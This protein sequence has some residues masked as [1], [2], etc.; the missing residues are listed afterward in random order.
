MAFQN[1]A[2][3]DILKPIKNRSQKTSLK[4]I[5][6]AAGAAAVWRHD[7]GNWNASVWPNPGA[8]GPKQIVIKT[9]GSVINTLINSKKTS[10][11]SYKL[12]DNIVFKIGGIQ[13]VKFEQTGR[14]TDTS[15][16][17]IPEST[18]TKMQETGSAWVFKRAIQDNARWN[19]WEDIREDHETYSVLRDIWMKI[20]KVQGPD[21]DWI[22]NFYKQNKALLAKIGRPGFTEF[23]RGSDYTFPGM[24]PPGDT[25]MDWIESKVKKSGGWGLDYAKKDSWN[26]ADIWLVQNEDKWRKLIDDQMKTIVVTP[27]STVSNLHQL[28]A[29]FRALFKSRQVFGISLKK[30]SG[31]TAKAVE[32]NADERFF[33]DLEDLCMSYEKSRCALGKKDGREGEI[34]METQ[35]SRFYIKNGNTVFNFQIKANTSTSFSGLKYEATEE[36]ASAARLGKAT[37]KFVMDLLKSYGLT[38]QTSESSYPNNPKAFM[39][40]WDTYKKKLE[41]LKRA[42]VDFGSAT[43]VAEALDNL[44]FVF[45]TEPHVANSKLQQITWLDTV[46]SLSKNDLDKFGTD[47]VFLSKKEGRDYGPFLKIY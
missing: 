46:L 27:G 33:L 47:L 37:V 20:G 13:T 8:R 31:S 25:F 28:N 44:L 22:Q 4:S 39:D 36:G 7:P 1:I 2:K 30:V 21:D 29:M 26:P 5:L 34:T 16:K 19:K 11:V 35:D 17:S 3:E 41:R 45:G 10:A 23:C 42:G 32:V 43:S 24:K 14:L 9:G 38:F 6:D 40:E 15:G 18:I 12:G